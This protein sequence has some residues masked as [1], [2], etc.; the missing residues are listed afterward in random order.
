MSDKNFF[1]SKKEIAQEREER[2][3]VYMGKLLDRHDIPNDYSSLRKLSDAIDQSEYDIDMDE[4][5][6]SKCKTVDDVLEI[7]NE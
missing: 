5:D 3:F 4:I 6:L 1:L 7:I 2:W